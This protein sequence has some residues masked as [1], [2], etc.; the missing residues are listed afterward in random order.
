MFI[1]YQKN[2]FSYEVPTKFP[3]EHVR[4]RKNFRQKY[5]HIITCLTKYYRSITTRKMSLYYQSLYEKYYIVRVCVLSVYYNRNLHIRH[6]FIYI[7]YMYAYAVY[8]LR[9]C[10][11]FSC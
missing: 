8:I 10:H 4:L 11:E 2:L 1:S 5:L 3:L 6:H 9:F 7:V